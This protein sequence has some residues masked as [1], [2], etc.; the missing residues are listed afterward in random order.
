MDAGLGGKQDVAFGIE[1]LYLFQQVAPVHSQQFDRTEI[2]G[3]D[4]MFL[5]VLG[6]V[7]ENR[8]A[9]VTTPRTG[10]HQKARLAPA[11]PVSF[12]LYGFLL[13]WEHGDVSEPYG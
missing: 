13:I 10:F 12:K 4:A 5:V 7:Q 9:A 6:T 2:D 8:R 11:F 3:H 1:H